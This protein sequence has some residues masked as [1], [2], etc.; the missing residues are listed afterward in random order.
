MLVTDLDVRQTTLSL[1]SRSPYSLGSSASS[2][3]RAA[4]RT[5]IVCSLRA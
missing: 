2:T 5:A 1:T 3:I 4:K